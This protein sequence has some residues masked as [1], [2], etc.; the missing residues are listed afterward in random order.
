MD[1]IRMSTEVKM[2]MPDGKKKR[3]TAET[4]R[5]CNEGGLK[6]GCQ[7]VCWG[8]LDITVQKFYL[9]FLLL[10]LESLRNVAAYNRILYI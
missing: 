2:E 7:T 9:T 8:L 4:V 5:G 1:G 6:G 3:K 10:M